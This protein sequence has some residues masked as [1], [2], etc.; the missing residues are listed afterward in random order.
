MRLIRYAR[1][2]SI[3]QL[4]GNEMTKVVHYFQQIASPPVAD[5]NDSIMPL[6]GN[7]MTEPVS[8]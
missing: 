5:R 2:D 3:K 4:L 8:N 6:R 7:E 1:N